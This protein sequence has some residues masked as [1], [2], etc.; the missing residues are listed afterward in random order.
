MNKIFISGRLVRD[1]E[2]KTTA[3]G[4]EFCTL[5]VAVDR[6]RKDSNG[7]RQ[8][9]FFDVTAW[10]KTGVFVNQYFKKGDG[11]NIEGR[12][13]SR[14]YV[15]GD[16]KNRVFWGLTVDNVE[17]PLSR[18]GGNQGAASAPAEP[19]F[20]EAADPDGDLPF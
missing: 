9:D 3:S 19:E 16:G 8:T 4:T 6:R 12:M 13:E 5:T 2:L 15:D 20:S 10:S 14:K 17:F 18:S 7:E 1:P 11:I